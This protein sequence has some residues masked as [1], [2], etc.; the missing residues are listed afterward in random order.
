MK[1][2]AFR[3]RKRT[4]SKPFLRRSRRE[5]NS[6][7]NVSSN[8]IFLPW[9]RANMPSS[10][11]GCFQREHPIRTPHRKSELPSRRIGPFRSRSTRSLLCSVDA[12]DR[13]TSAVS[14][15]SWTRFLVGSVATSFLSAT[16]QG[17]PGAGPHIGVETHGETH[18]WGRN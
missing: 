15:H 6:T 13:G 12:D 7:G 14:T 2:Q 1:Q 10:S 18:S 16:G 8:L 9:P 17:T 3:P 5:N 4:R 11:S